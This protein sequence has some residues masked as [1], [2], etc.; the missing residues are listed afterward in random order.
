M[1]RLILTGLAVYL[2]AGLVWAQTDDT[3]D[4]RTVLGGGKDHHASGS[5]PNSAGH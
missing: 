5:N 1:G 4:K 2:V 3:P